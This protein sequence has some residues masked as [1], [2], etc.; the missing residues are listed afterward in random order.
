MLNKLSAKYQR[1]IA[2]SFISLFFITGLASAK[3][4]L[5]L[6]APPK[7]Y[8]S[9]IQ[10]HQFS[11][12]D[13]YAHSGN[14][15]SIQ[16]D[17]RNSF[18]N[19]GKKDPNNKWHIGLADFRNKPAYDLL[20][21]KN[22]KIV[23]LQV[24]K[25]SSPNIGGPSQPEMG[26]F[27]S[28]GSDN[29]VTP[30]TGD[31]S[32]NIPLL[33]VGG[34]P[35]N[36]FYNSGITMDQDASWVGLGWNINPGTITRNMR[37]IP[38]DFDGTDV[39]TKTQSVRTDKTWGVS[40][41]GGVKLAGYPFSVGVDV[42]TGLS[43]NNKLGLALDASI[44]PSLGI[45][46][47]SGDSKTASL[48]FAASLN[49]SSRNGA[50]ITPSVSVSAED[51]N[52]DE[53]EKTTASLGASYTYSSRMGIEGMHLDASAS[54]SKAN[55]DSK[56]QSINDASQGTLSSG[57]SFLYPTICPSVQETFT[58]RSYN[59]SF[60]IGGEV[61]ALNLHG[62]LAGYYT[63]NG[64]DPSDQTTTHPAYGML[65]YQN[66]NNDSRALLDFNRANDGCYTP[67][68]PTVAMPVYTYDIFS[69]TGEGTGGSF[70]ATRSDLGY[71]RDPYVKTKDNS[72]SLGV[73]LGFG[74]A[75][76]GG[77]TLTYVYTPTTAGSWEKSNVAA[78]VLKF[79]GS[80][81]DYQSVYFRNPGEKTI[82]NTAY[83]NLVLG[84][85][86]LV[87]FRMTDIGS[88]TPTLSSNLIQ[89]DQNRNNIGDITLTANS[90][91]DPIRSKRTQVIS[92]L[93]AA[94]AEKVA[95]DKKILSYNT[96][97]SDPSDNVILGGCN[98]GEIEQIDRVSDYRLGHHISEIN[99]LGT[100]GRKYVYGLPVYNICQTDVSFS[101][102]NGTGNTATGKTTYQSGVDDKVGSNG[103]GRDWHQQSESI[104]AYTHSFLLTALVSPN[105]VDVTGDG[106][107]DDDIGDAIKFNYT[108]FTQNY[109]W[110][111]PVGAQPIVNGSNITGEAAYSE[112]LKTDDKD[113]KGHYVYGKREL[114]HLYSIESKSM[115]ARFYIKNDRKDC[116]Q[117][118][119]KSGGIDKDWG[120]Q[121]LDRICLYSKSDVLKLGTNAKPIKTIQFFQSYKLCGN[122]D[123]N[124]GECIDIN[125]NVNCDPTK[126]I[127]ANKGKL[128]LDSILITY[129]GNVKKAKS[130]YVFYYP[131][132]A[133]QNPNYDYTSNDRW[134]NY[135]PSD[136]TLNNNLGNLTNAD[137]PYAIQNK[138]KADAY[139]AAWTMDSVL[140]PSGGTIHV[141]YEADDYAYVQDKKAANM[142]PVL[143]FGTSQSSTPSPLLYASHNGTQN[144]YVFIDISAHPINTSE[145]ISQQQQDLVARYLQNTTS[146]YMKL[147]VIMPSSPGLAGSELLPIYAPIKNYGVVPG[148]KMAWVQV[149]PAADGSTPMVHMS[150]QFIKQQIPGKAYPGYDLS[151]NAGT[152]AIVLALGNM[153]TSIGSLLGGDDNE[154]R[155]QNICQQVDISKS[156]ARLT[157]PTFCKR[158]G[159]LRVKRI[160][161]N[162]NWN[163]M[164]KQY[165]ATYGQEYKYTTTELINNKLTTISSGVA[166]WEPSIGEDENPHKDILSYVDHNKGGPYNYGGVG[167][168]LGE[169]YYPSP[170][171]GYSRVEVLSIHRDTVKNAPTRQVS[172]F[173]TNKDFPFK[174][175]C[176]D[177]NGDPEAN[178]S[179]APNPILQ[180]L[181]INREKAITQSQGF[182]ID[183]N[184]MNGKMITQSTYAADDS[185]NP[186][187]YTK[188]F[189]NVSKTTD[190]TYSFDH[191]FPTL[192]QPNGVITNSVIGRDVELMED[193]REHTSQ[194]ITTSMDLNFDFFF[195]GWF[196]VIIPTMLK[197]P[198]VEGTGYRSAAV[199]KIVNHYGVIDSVETVD[200]GS[201]VSTHDLVY[202][203]QTG[204]PLLTRTNNE[205]N[206]PIYNFSYP[207][208]WAYSG[209]GSAYKNIDYTYSG[210]TF[211]NGLIENPPA[212]LDMSIFESG[213]ELYVNS[214]TGKA[215]ASTSC[216]RSP[217][218][219]DPA[220]KVWAVYTGKV[221]AS[222]AEMVFMDSIGTPYT[223][224]NV[225]IRIIRSGHRNMLD[226]MVGSITSL[227]NPIDP[228]T[229]TLSFNDGTNVIQT[230]AA[231]FKDHWRVDDAWYGVNTLVPI[232]TSH[233]IQLYVANPIANMNLTDASCKESQSG[234]HYFQ[235]FNQQYFT[236]SYTSD[237]PDKDHCAPLIGCITSHHSRAYTQA[238]AMF[239]F[240]SIPTGATIANA[241]LSFEPHDFG[242]KNPSAYIHEEEFLCG[243]S[244]D[245]Y[246]SNPHN[247]V[248]END[249]YIAR[250]L[251]SFGPTG[252]GNILHDYYYNQNYI[253]QNYIIH[254]PATNSPTKSYYHWDQCS[255]NPDNSFDI[256][257][258]AQKML[259]DN[260]DPTKGTPVVI[261]LSHK[262]TISDNLK[263]GNSWGANTNYPRVCF[264]PPQMYIYY[265][266]CNDNGAASN[267]NS[268]DVNFGHTQN[269]TSLQYR[270]ICHSVFTQPTINPYVR[271]ILGDWRVDTTYAYYAG[272]KETLPGTPVDTRTGGAIAGY[273]PFWN[274]NNTSYLTRNTSATGWTWNSTITQYNRKGY[275]IENKDP[276]GRYNSGLYGYDEQLPTAVANNAREEEVMFDGFEDYNYSTP[277]DCAACK[278][279]RHGSFDN[280]S[281]PTDFSPTIH[282]TG[283][284]SL[285]VNPGASITLETPLVDSSVKDAAGYGLNVPIIPPKGGAACINAVNLGNTQITG[286]AL[287]DSLILLK[288]KKMLLSAWVNEN[289]AN[290][291]CSTYV[292]NSI[293]V[294]FSSGVMG[295]SA[296][297]TLYPTGNIIEGWQRYESI[298]NVP[299]TATALQLSLNNLTT[300]PSHGPDLPV[301]FDDIRIEPFN[302]NLKSF[303]YNSSNLRLMAELD[304]NNY[305][306]FY[307]Y[308][309]DGTL[310]RVKK[311]TERGIQTIT[312]TRSAMQKLIVQ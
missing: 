296:T 52:D 249:F 221:E 278:P 73:D 7:E 140:L 215:P 33:D 251:N 115:V 93:N 224:D 43:M 282:H 178:V 180:L 122:V 292:N 260:R 103:Q 219:F 36:M 274:F 207:A 254:A 162:D 227:N 4:Q 291:K 267:V 190:S 298:I 112:N 100:D 156:F 63:E 30:F 86:N 287:N 5:Y 116:K 269:C 222:P 90:V 151:E 137:Y 91:I 258:M 235:S 68:A 299:A 59:L 25:T 123:N 98:N 218:V 288:G 50:S 270:I 285:I 170:S 302:A 38:D 272:R 83:Q 53:G 95:L 208:R 29:M 107:S 168:P 281:F 124:N 304:E 271:G 141:D 236:T 225:N 133:Q 40:V 13:N 60:D 114:W 37:G 12:P 82:P 132:S 284:Y 79:Q 238:W 187:S 158:G 81:K 211:R 108:R 198:I 24:N 117:A 250:A 262:L 15:N 39:I 144:D 126:N 210:L 75:V 200:R 252:D 213:D 206:T 161:I 9:Y 142:C 184:D 217:L 35:I 147:A 175:S 139:A 94:D 80:S 237:G 143:G 239:D 88:G 232:T 154:I 247:D 191:N 164:T 172:E 23:H 45:S 61:D 131:T 264:E 14:N 119:G 16:I 234:H 255:G 46:K 242:G 85:E 266:N 241:R 214:T 54:K 47:S 49:V 153:I 228:N 69:I 244:N 230:S 56:F 275:E 130:K 297:L 220:N 179:F 92:F 196:P 263:D 246:A 276:L 106:I 305:A 289:N 110:R 177:L 189:Y 121:R 201:M 309:D 204:N 286:T 173:Y 77:A 169:V 65:Y 199:L 290:C 11:Y 212:D 105:Y 118:L 6:I 311:E 109:K 216:D 148:G 41:G 62:T 205:H 202:D 248:S 10:Q 127:N 31:F 194:T 261:R 176:T 240:S 188:N 283:L 146:L 233:Q 8:H 27:K 182:L 84:G 295:S 157:N 89:Y 22:R 64:I 155:K 55:D 42:S 203:A 301:Y 111:T 120:M 150:I 18:L 71:M 231:T 166:A 306:T 185:I 135:K 21:N 223:A 102:D 243:Y 66:G 2:L 245:H 101:I 273:Q 67:A 57:M 149:Q 183:M 58:R 99:V 294:L 97:N 70:R 160:V 163:A 279:H 293:T 186:I 174:S 303:V 113:D 138:A 129:N 308:D 265:F 165:D 20:Y 76:H 257:A 44:S 171:V 19:I 277:A 26:R 209:M 72:Y 307:E 78:S 3:S 74:D 128:T 181:N 280:I 312:E 34:Y 256:T 1:E 159:G 48:S 28:V 87:R 17:K 229:N 300:S 253:D 310:T 193:F 226:Q 51:D 104:P 96:D 195:I 145:S 197:P 268:C 32:Y 192:D 136:N 125:G 152:K 134:G 167:L 259:T